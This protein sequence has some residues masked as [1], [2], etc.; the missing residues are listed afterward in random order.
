M[1]IVGYHVAKTGGTTVMH[2]IVKHMGENAYFG[3][4]NH[5]ATTRFFNNQPLWEELS[6]EERSPVKFVFGHHVNDR[7][8]VG[9][10]ADETALFSVVRDPYAHFVS[11]YKHHL[12]TI[13]GEGRNVGA[14]A[15]FENWKSNRVAF[16]FYKFFPALLPKQDMPFEE[17]ALFEILKQFRFLCATEKLTEQS[18]AIT[19][20]LGIP[21]I[22]GRFRVSKDT[23]DLEGITPEEVYEKSPLDLKIYKAVLARANGEESPLEYD[24]V[25]F[26]KSLERTTRRYSSNR[27]VRLAYDALAQ[28][29]RANSMLQAAQIHLAVS[30]NNEHRFAPIIRSSPNQR[31]LANRKMTARAEK[32]QGVVYLQHFMNPLARACF[33]KAI[34]L[35]PAYVDAYV[36]LARCFIRLKDPEAAMKAVCY[37]LNNLDA[38]NAG[39]KM[40][41]EELGTQV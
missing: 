29:F 6:D 27:T 31:T 12:T 18:L 28:F 1:L 25:A 36:D 38:N 15:Y 22:E 13:R 16:E 8:L 30:E 14:R 4:G 9:R 24:S 33:E 37:V 10:S 40:V 20:E 19:S 32:E 41:F 34:A 11:Q 23:V 21:Q 35:N 17:E 26:E 5:P 7:L 2:H 39:A 3:Y